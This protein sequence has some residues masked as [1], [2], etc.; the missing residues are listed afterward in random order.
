MKT[1]II[2]IVIGGLGVELLHLFRSRIEAWLLAKEK[3]LTEPEVKP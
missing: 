3:K 2:G 1:L